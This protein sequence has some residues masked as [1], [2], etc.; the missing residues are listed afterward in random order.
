MGRRF[1]RHYA[2]TRSRYGR[3][4][5]WRRAADQGQWRGARAG[6]GVCAAAEWHRP[7]GWSASLSSGAQCPRRQPQTGGRCTVSVC[8]RAC[9]A[10]KADASRRSV[11]SRGA[12]V[13][14]PS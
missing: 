9:T 11:T 3:R 6:T 1:S 12:H 8:V 2:T 14:A 7:R 13:P 5:G 10:A 4:G